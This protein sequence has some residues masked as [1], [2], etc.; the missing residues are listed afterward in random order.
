MKSAGPNTSASSR[1]EHP[2]ICSTP[3]SPAASSIWASIPIPPCGRPAACSTLAEQQ[4]Q[5]GDVV[6]A[7]HLGQDR[8]CPAAARRARQRRPRPGRPTGCG[9]VHPHGPDLAAPVPG[10]QR[11]GHIGPRFVFRIRRDRVFQVEQDLVSVEARGFVQKSRT[12]ARHRNA[13]PPWPGHP[14]PHP[15]I[16]AL[17]SYSSTAADTATLS[18]SAEPSIGIPIRRKPDACQGGEIPYRSLPTTSAVRPL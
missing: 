18:E 11:G 10:L 2:A 15:F 4:V 3:A 6:G 7:T 13:G 5:P 1:G 9:A 17:A 8:A 12:T 16:C 14:P